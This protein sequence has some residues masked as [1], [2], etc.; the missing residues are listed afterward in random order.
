MKKEEIIMKDFLELKEKGFIEGEFNNISEL[1]DLLSDLLCI[2]YEEQNDLQ[3][4]FNMLNLI[5]GGLINKHQ[6]VYT[7]G[8]KPWEILYNEDQPD[9]VLRDALN[10]WNEYYDDNNETIDDLC[11]SVMHRLL[12]TMSNVGC[13]VFNALKMILDDIDVKDNII[14][15]S[16]GELNPRISFYNS[17]REI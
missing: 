14:I 5:L 13:D 12:D 6:C 9:D 15:I 4:A 16:Y 1:C 8:T 11:S 17:E 2:I 7:V 3:S 10:K